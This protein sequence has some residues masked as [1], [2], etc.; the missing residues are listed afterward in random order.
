MSELGRPKTFTEPEQL[1]SHFKDYVQ[2]NNDNPTITKHYN[3][4][5]NTTGEVEHTTPLTMRGFN[6]YLSKRNICKNLYEYV[7]N[8]N[9]SYN[10]F[11]TIIR[12]IKDEIFI[13]KFAGAA[14]G[15]YQHNIIARETGMVDKKEMEVKEI[16]MT[17]EEKERR[18]AELMQKAKDM[19][20]PDKLRL[21]SI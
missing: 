9:N 13:Q 5:T 19:L 7:N 18:L 15:E 17:L 3:V 14:V 6:V 16:P 11:T 1:Y 21:K 4:K 10:N 8:N 12:T 20:P 2:W